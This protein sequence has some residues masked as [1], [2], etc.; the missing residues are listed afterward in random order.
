MRAK[1]TRYRALKV[2]KRNANENYT[3]Y[4]CVIKCQRASLSE[5]R[6]ETRL[7]GGMA[8]NHP[9]TGVVAKVLFFLENIGG[10]VNFVVGIT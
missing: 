7:A 2:I 5:K 6:Q 3:H 10:T 9:E 8:R 1:M 4:E